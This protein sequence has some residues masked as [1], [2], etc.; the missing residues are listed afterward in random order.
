[1]ENVSADD[2]LK[3]LLEGNQRF[4]KG[5]IINPHQVVRRRKE[6]IHGQRPFAVIIGCS[7]SRVP[8][9]ILFDQGL[10]DLFIIRA[11]G[12]TVDN[13]CIGSLEFALE[14]LDVNLVIVLGH[15][16]CGLI[17][18]AANGDDVHHHLG[19]LVKTASEAVEKTRCMPGDHLENATKE[20]VRILIETLEKN[21]PTI[22]KYI[23]GGKVKIVGCYYSLDTGKVDIIA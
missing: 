18:T 11:A 22:E 7:D 9:E 13:V 5:E 6:I 16:Y 21:S 19:S 20:N 17:E 2:A 10:G 12:V 4:I 14:H 15:Q 1:M 3:L 8:P 23:T